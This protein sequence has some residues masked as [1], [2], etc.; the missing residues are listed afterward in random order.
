[1]K[2][3][4]E[5]GLVEIEGAESSREKWILMKMMKDT[6]L[7][8]L[9]NTY[10]NKLVMAA[11]NFLLIAISVYS[12]KTMFVVGQSIGSFVYKLLH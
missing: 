5:D 1:M 12:L 3:L 9:N 10:E 6:F 4:K 2:D 11:F 8:L 7:A